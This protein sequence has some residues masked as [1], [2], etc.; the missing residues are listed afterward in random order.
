MNITT[1]S[2]ITQQQAITLAVN[3]HRN[4]YNREDKVWAAATHHVLYDVW[5][6]EVIGKYG[7]TGYN[8]WNDD[9][10]DHVDLISEGNSH[11]QHHVDVI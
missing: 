6:V 5:F 3:S 11:L 2:N 7:T 1:P 9:H 4:R 8:I 10:G